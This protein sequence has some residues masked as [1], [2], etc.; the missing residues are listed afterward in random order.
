[1]FPWFKNWNGITYTEK[2][3]I[4]LN[5]PFVLRDLRKTKNKCEIT[6]LR[7]FIEQ[8]DY[9]NFAE[10]I[11]FL[12]SVCEKCEKPQYLNAKINTFLP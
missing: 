6:V 12:L 2:T 9:Y 4:R 11:G 3:C 7:K 8:I 5:L 1:M 10:P